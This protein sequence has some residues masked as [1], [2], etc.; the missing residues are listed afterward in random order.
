MVIADIFEALTAADRPYKRAK[1]LSVAIDILH[2]FAL[3]QHIDIDLFELFLTSGAY[4][5]YANKFIK[6]EQVN[7][8]DITKYLRTDSED[9]VLQQAYA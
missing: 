7:E 8:V 4:L 6:T 9:V 2:K 3:D 1:S 5:S